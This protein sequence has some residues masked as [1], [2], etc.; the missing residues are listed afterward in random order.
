MQLMRDIAQMMAP[1]VALI[2]LIVHC[3]LDKK[4]FARKE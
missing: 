2:G 4:R 1:W 3:R